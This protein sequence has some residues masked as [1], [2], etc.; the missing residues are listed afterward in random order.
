MGGSGENCTA[1]LGRLYSGL[2]STLS[3][4]S[5]APRCTFRAFSSRCL[6]LCCAFSSTFG[7]ALKAPLHSSYDQC[8][9]HFKYV[10]DLMSEA[11]FHPIADE[12]LEDIMDSIEDAFEDAGL[13]NYEANY[14]VG[15]SIV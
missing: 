4:P 6:L 12:T 14:A 15:S 13:E 3:L 2:P 1:S 8:K 11:E 7:G 9:T 5:L 10:S